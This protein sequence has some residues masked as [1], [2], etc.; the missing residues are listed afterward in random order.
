MVSEAKGE[1][2]LFLMPYF[3]LF[4][5]TVMKVFFFFY[6]FLFSQKP[7]INLRTWTLSSLDWFRVDSFWMLY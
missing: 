1:S 4:V 2:S 7:E 5:M 3:D 6:A